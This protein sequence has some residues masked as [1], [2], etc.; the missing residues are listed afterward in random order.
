MEAGTPADWFH[1]ALW[2]L[3]MLRTVNPAADTIPSSTWHTM[4]NDVDHRLLPRSEGIRDAR[5]P[6][7]ALTPL[8]FSAPTRK[9][10]S[11]RLR[12]QAGV[13][14]PVR[15][16]S[17]ACSPACGSRP[18]RSRARPRSSPPGAAGP[19]AE[20]RPGRA[21]RGWIH[22]RSGTESSESRVDE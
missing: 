10:L 6:G 12:G 3:A 11:V 20:S 18:A 15:S 1:S 13:R 17:S 4:I 8:V 14:S 19:G 21:L 9:T 7:R 16:R 2:A 22:S 5:L